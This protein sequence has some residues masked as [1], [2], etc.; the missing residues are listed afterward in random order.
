MTLTKQGDQQD[1]SSTL[2]TARQY[3]TLLQLM[4]V[5]DPRKIDTYLLETIII[6]YT[7]K[8]YI[9][10][11]RIYCSTETL[12]IWEETIGTSWLRINQ[13]VQRRHSVTLAFIQFGTILRYFDYP[14]LLKTTEQTCV[15]ISCS[16]MLR[17]D[18]KASIL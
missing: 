2:S 18:L 7:E 6:F 1:I 12:Q 11:L 3:F 9:I 14:H 17:L 15:R 8:P 5:E 4:L 10:N 13:D 16:R